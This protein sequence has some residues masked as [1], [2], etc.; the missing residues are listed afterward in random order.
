MNAFLPVAASLVKMSALLHDPPEAIHT[1]DDSRL[2]WKSIILARVIQGEVSLTMA[3]HAG[4]PDTV[5]TR[6]VFKIL[7]G[8]RALLSG[9]P[10]SQLGEWPVHSCN[11][12]C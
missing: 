7:C 11:H 1:V 10:G 8:L 5:S 12:I 6:S 3:F 9:G 2:M 4:R